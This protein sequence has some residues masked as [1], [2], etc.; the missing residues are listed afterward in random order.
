MKNLYICCGL[1]GLIVLA[2]KLGQHTGA[3][4]MAITSTIEPELVRR[5]GENAKD[6]YK[7]TATIRKLT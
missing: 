1:C 6:R 2:Y 3:I 5:I 7:A 4:T